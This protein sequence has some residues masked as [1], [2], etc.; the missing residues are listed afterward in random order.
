MR[1]LAIA[2]DIDPESL[3]NDMND[4]AIFA[5]ILRGLNVGQETGPQVDQGGQQ[6]GGMAGVGGVPAGANSDDAQGTGDGNIG[7]GN[8]PQSGESNFTGSTPQT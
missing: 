7:V 3:V 8:V 1:E 2:Q 5:E 4:A 6:P